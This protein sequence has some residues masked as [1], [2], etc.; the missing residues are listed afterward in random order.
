MRLRVSD[1]LAERQMTAYEL[2]KRSGGRIG[3]STAYRLARGEWKALSETV[4][5]ALCD[6]LEIDDPGPLFERQARPKRRR[7]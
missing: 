5:D 7:D 2:A 3:I 6:V 4:L 1:L